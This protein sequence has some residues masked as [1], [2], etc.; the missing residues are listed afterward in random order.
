VIDTH[1]ILYEVQIKHSR[2]CY[3]EDIQASEDE[4]IESIYNT[5][6]LSFE[7]S[8]YMDGIEGVLEIPKTRKRLNIY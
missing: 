8:F 1:C 3:L 4:T 7:I 2:E 6:I 5:L